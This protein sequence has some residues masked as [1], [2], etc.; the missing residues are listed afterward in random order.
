[1]GENRAEEGGSVHIDGIQMGSPHPV[2]VDGRTVRD[3]VTGQFAP[4]HASPGRKPKSTE[5]AYLDA[6][7][8]AM[9]PEVIADL[10]AEALQLARDT[11]SWRGMA[12]IISIALQYGAGKP[13]QK[14][15][16]TD[17]NLEALLAVLAD[18]K[19]LLPEA[20]KQGAGEN[21]SE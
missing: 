17:G 18:D 12:E 13:T 1:M 3:A 10:L 11:R 9:P 2:V 6:V 8:Q 4:G 15:V 7:K 14:T 20:T 16:T 21:V 19:P 5:K